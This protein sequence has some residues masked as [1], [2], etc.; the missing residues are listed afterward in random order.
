MFFTACA[1]A[2]EAAPKV[3]ASAIIAVNKPLFNLFVSVNVF[4]FLYADV[5]LNQRYKGASETASGNM[6]NFP[7]TWGYFPDAS[8]SMLFLNSTGE[9]AVYFLKKLAK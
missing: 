6:R 1:W 2:D 5:C 8:N 7:M 9:S 4:M 3:T